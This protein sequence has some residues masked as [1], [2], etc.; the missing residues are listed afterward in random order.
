M[1]VH[2]PSGSIHSGGA[3]ISAPGII[4]LQFNDDAFDLKNVNITLDNGEQ[5]TLNNTDGLV[6]S[7]A[8]ITAGGTVRA[9]SG[10]Y[11]GAHSSSDDNKW[12][13]N[14][15]ITANAITLNQSV[16]YDAPDENQCANAPI[17]LPNASNDGSGVPFITLKNNKYVSVNNNTCDA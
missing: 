4:P 14:G 6:L 10:L 2:P 12:E 13:P 3:R 11:I 17:K 15:D 8:S 1:W 5:S 16:G 7:N 9:E